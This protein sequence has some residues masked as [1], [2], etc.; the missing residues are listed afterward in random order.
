MRCLVVPDVRPTFAP[1]DYNPIVLC[2]AYAE[3]LRAAGRD[4]QLTEY[5]NSP[6]SFDNPLGAQPAVALPNSQSV[7]NCKIREEP[8]GLLI[9][10]TTK[11]PFTYKDACVERGPHVGYDPDATQQAKQ[12]V[13]EFMRTALKFN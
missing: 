9:N 2:K 4:V 12:M 3:R 7:R 6:H 10:A 1:D 5:R 8:V 11:E 13:K